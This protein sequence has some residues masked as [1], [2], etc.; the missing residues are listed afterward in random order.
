M[1]RAGILALLTVC[2]LLTF[3]AIGFAQ[4][5]EPAQPDT[6]STS[7]IYNPPRVITPDYK[8]GEEP[9]TEYGTGGEKAVPKPS[10][11]TARNK[12]GTAPCAACSERSRARVGGGG[13]FVT[14][15]LF[16][17]LDDLNRQIRRMGIP[18]LAEQILIAGGRGYTRIG[19]LLIGGAGYGGDTESSGVPD[20]CARSAQIEIAY[21]G[22]LLGLAVSR[23]RYE[24][25]GGMLFG[26]GSVRVVRERNSRGVTDWEGAWEDFYEGGPDSVATEDLNITSEIRGEFVVLE[27]F[28]GL[29]YWIMP[30]MALDLSASY[31]QA[32]IGRGDWQIDGVS[33]PDSPESNIGGWSLRLGLHFGV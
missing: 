23:P 10:A 5:K 18:V 14:G 22:V 28:A 7:D 13:E 1:K 33:I 30:F 4:G 26:G 16:A 3:C 25:M 12:P 20:C 17:N 6:T 15:Y 8:A 21:G 31:L 11:D 29:K 19:H 9:A 2:A 24:I 32:P 27:P